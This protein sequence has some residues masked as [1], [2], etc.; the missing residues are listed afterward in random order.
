MT[1]VSRIKR[2]VLKVVPTLGASLN[3]AVGRTI[4]HDVVGAIAARAV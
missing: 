3:I 1:V 4:N 2:P